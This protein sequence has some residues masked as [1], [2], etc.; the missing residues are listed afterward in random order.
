MQATR[1]RSLDVTPTLV[2]NCFL[3]FPVSHGVNGH[4]LTFLLP[5]TGLLWCA[6]PCRPDGKKSPATLNSRQ[7]FLFCFCQVVRTKYNEVLDLDEGVR[8]YLIGRC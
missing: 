5:Q 1:G 8:K 2:L 7:S 6:V 3:C 4:C